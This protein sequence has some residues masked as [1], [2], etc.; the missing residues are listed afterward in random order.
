MALS[1]EKIRQS[2]TFAVEG[3]LSTLQGE[4][5]NFSR[6]SPTMLDLFV[7]SS[8]ILLPIQSNIPAIY[9][10]TGAILLEPSRTNLLNYNLDL[11]QNVWQKGGNVTIR[12]DIVLAPDGSQRGDRVSWSVGTGNTQLVQRTVALK[13]G[14]TYCLSAII[15]LVGG[16]VASSDVLRVIGAVVGTPLVALTSLNSYLKNYRWVELSFTTTGRQ[17][18]LPINAQDRYAIVALAANSVTLS[19][20]FG[21]VNGDLV[22]GRIGFSNNQSKRYE[23]VSNTI[24]GSNLVVTT[25]PISGNLISDGV[26]TADTAQIYGAADVAATI[27][28]YVESAISLDWGGAQLEEGNFRTSI[29][30]QDANI[31]S[32]AQTNLVYRKFS[33]P[34]VGLKTFTLLIDIAFWRGNGNIFTAGNISLEIIAGKLRATVG[35]TVFDIAQ[36]LSKS[37]QICLQVSGEAFALTLCINKVVV[38]RSSL[39]GFQPSLAPIVLTSTGV[40]CFSRILVLNQ[41]FGDGGVNIGSIVQSEL[42]DVLFSEITDVGAVAVSIPEIVLPS[43]TV[44]S[45]E[46]PAASSEIQAINSAGRTVTV[47]DGTNFGTSGAV[48]IYRSAPDGDRSI[49]SLTITGKTGNTI[50]LDSVAGIALGDKL[51]SDFVARPGKASVRMPFSP[52]DPQ[53]ITAIDSGNKRVT[54]ASALSFVEKRRAIVQSSLYQD[55]AEVIVESVD[56]A[57]SRLTL[58]SIFNISLGDIISQ[59]DEEIEIPVECYYVDLLTPNPVI[60]IDQK[61]TNGFVLS[62]K[63]IGDAIVQTTVKV[64]L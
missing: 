53:I 34:L 46:V 20:V 49:A 55:V 2:I 36:D 57:N 13:A 30:Y 40:R 17:P 32:R 16:R 24:S 47:I 41:A 25:D 14:T 60:N 11:R 26:T 44:P 63:G 64:Y 43:V 6:M 10:E 5:P 3:R 61:A 28:F 48:L 19:G 52:I 31:A 38:A 39:A 22:G 12:G 21:I 62:N 35:T 37:P 45:P 56:N 8:L 18:Q 33:N 4:V 23:I 51:V 1:L 7:N 42:A 58:S 54:V 15:K 27:Q 50:S 59:P 29:I 9:P